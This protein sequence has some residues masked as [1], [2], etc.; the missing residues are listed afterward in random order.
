MKLRQLILILSVFALLTIQSLTAAPLTPN[1]FSDNYFERLGARN[2]DSQDDIKKAYRRAMLLFHPD[3]I[4]QD[5]VLEVK[6]RTDAA[7][8]IGEAY[9]SIINGGS[10][11]QNTYEA[12]PFPDFE[13][14]GTAQN[15]GAEI[16]RASKKGT[17]LE[18]SSLASDLLAH[19]KSQGLKRY[20]ENLFSQSWANLGAV[21]VRRL[22]P[23]FMGEGLM[24][25]ALSQSFESAISKF[26]IEDTF[27]VVIVP[28]ELKYAQEMGEPINNIGD[29][30]NIQIGA[31]TYWLTIQARAEKSTDGKTFANTFLDFEQIGINFLHLID[32]QPFHPAIIAALQKLASFRGFSDSTI[33]RAVFHIYRLVKTGVISPDQ[34]RVYGAWSTVTRYMDRMELRTEE[35][36]LNHVASVECAELL[37]NQMNGRSAGL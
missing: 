6:R 26:F 22:P 13:W 31:M 3:L 35:D 28:Q 9:Q 11:F 14:E 12:D 2:T 23:F 32:R 18:L 19:R 8:R 27:Q 10:N 34:D 7:K 37:V 20:M 15:I 16:S 1:P 5:D 29:V 25:V 4:R 36:F 21:G 30:I 33:A 24:L 17:W